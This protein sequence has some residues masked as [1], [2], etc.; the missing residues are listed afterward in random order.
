MWIFLYNFRQWS[1]NHPNFKTLGRYGM[2]GR[3]IKVMKRPTL[4]TAQEKIA[5][6]S[7]TNDIVK[8]NPY[9]PPKPKTPPKATVPGKSGRPKGAKNKRFSAP[10]QPRKLRSTPATLPKATV[11]L[12]RRRPKEVKHLFLPNVEDDQNGRRPK[13]KTTKMEDDQNGR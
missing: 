3:L 4:V 13:W 6:Y 2:M 7:I 5:N 1:R 11:S 10:A 9:I 8:E 12:K